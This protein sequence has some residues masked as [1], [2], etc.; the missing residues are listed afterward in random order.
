MT[1]AS[2][3][4]LPK[5][6]PELIGRKRGNK[7]P[8]QLAPVP[9]PSA[10]SPAKKKLAA[11]VAAKPTPSPVS[12]SKKS[13]PASPK[14]MA[15]PAAKGKAKAAATGKTALTKKVTNE[16][17]VKSTEKMNGVALQAK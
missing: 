4:V 1:I 14:K 17:L 10:P 15:P 8:N 12:P 13:P 6:H 7:F 3:G 11:K 5:I 2:G 9:V 16:Q